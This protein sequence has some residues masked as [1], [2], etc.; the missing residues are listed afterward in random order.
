MKTTLLVAILIVTPAV[1]QTPADPG[2]A[3]DR[4][5]ITFVMT[6]FE[7][8]SGSVLCAL[9]DS[10]ESWLDD[11][12]DGVA[13]PIE[14]GRAVCTFENQ[15]P[16]DYGI[17]AHHDRDDDGKMKKLIG[18]P[19]EPYCFSRD[20]RGRIGP[21]SFARASFHH[22]GGNTVQHATLK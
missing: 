1:A 17:V 14:D 6:G 3:P 4:G 10:K 18:I 19:R 5:T 16:G 13:V 12:V 15:A 22:D 7:S 2:V 9:F 11:A 20:A 8:Q 21:P